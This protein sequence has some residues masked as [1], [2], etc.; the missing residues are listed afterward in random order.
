MPKRSKVRSSS[1]PKKTVIL[2]P[3]SLCTGRFF[4]LF[5]KRMDACIKNRL[6]RLGLYSKYRF[7]YVQRVLKH[8]TPS[9][10]DTLGLFRVELLG[11]KRTY[12]GALNQVD[13]VDFRRDVRFVTRQVHA[14]TVRVW[15][16]FGR[17]VF[18]HKFHIDRPS[19]ETVIATKLCQITWNLANALPS[20]VPRK[21]CLPAT[22]N[23]DAR[24]KYDWI[25]SCCVREV[26]IEMNLP[27]KASSRH[28]QNNLKQRTP[29]CLNRLGF[30][31][32]VSLVGKPRPLR[33]F[34]LLTVEGASEVS[35]K[36]SQALVLKRVRA[37]VTSTIIS[38][39]D[40]LPV[41]NRTNA[42]R[43]VA[44]HICSVIFAA[45]YPDV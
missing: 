21:P 1:A 20:R 41:N 10:L 3:Q 19:I 39:V 9:L 2:I 24:I 30:S 29:D 28:I 16:E 45:A 33:G 14:F 42:V 13:S 44:N 36:N 15:R 5:Q 6:V 38:D 18:I 7:L 17:G 12:A 27:S 26:F 40:A 25:L 34:R 37:F 35:I 22:V 43:S 31:P 4:L 23:C 11:A 32:K 8:Y